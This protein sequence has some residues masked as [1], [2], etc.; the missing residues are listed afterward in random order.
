MFGITDFVCTSRKCLPILWSMSHNVLILRLTLKTKERRPPAF[1]A[2]AADAQKMLQIQKDP[3]FLEL[4]AAL[5]AEPKSSRPS[6]AVPRRPNV[7][8]A[9]DETKASW[10]QHFYAGLRMLIETVNMSPDPKMAEKQLE[11]AYRWYL[12]SKQP[13]PTSCKAA[14]VG[15]NFHDFCADEVLRH[16]A[17]PGSAFYTPTDHE[18]EP[19]TSASVEKVEER[20][21]LI[22]SWD[23]KVNWI[24]KPS[25]ETM[26]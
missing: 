6:G 23:F 16:P 8:G 13:G 26:K 25:S 20:L 15:P 7:L 12:S 21:L 10:K 14:P 17:Q 9:L 5:Q 3:R 4:Q 22:F 11:E 2:R 1:A 18:G 19:V 24:G